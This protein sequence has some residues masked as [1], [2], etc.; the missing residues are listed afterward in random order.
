MC[1]G[2]SVQGHPRAWPRRPSLA[3]A[4]RTSPRAV[5]TQSAAE[6]AVA[7]E[8]IEENSMRFA[9]HPFSAVHWQ[10]TD[11]K[12]RFYRRPGMTSASI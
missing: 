8:F 4:A 5:G 11:E 7:R 10:W 3:K 6:T 2:A 1:R 9:T 12:T